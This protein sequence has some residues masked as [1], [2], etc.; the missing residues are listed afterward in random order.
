M[1]S[2]FSSQQREAQDVQLSQAPRNLRGRPFAAGQPKLRLGPAN[3][4]YEQEA[5][6][7]AAQVVRG[8]SAPDVEAQERAPQ[9][10]RFATAP[11]AGI[12]VPP[13]VEAGIAAARG[14]GHRLPAGVR[15]QME[16][17]MGADFGGVRLHSDNRADALNQ[18][19]HA[20][21]FTTGRDIFFRQGEYQPGSEVGRGL[22]AHE[23]AHVVQQRV[24]Y[25]VVQRAK[26]ID[27]DENEEIK[28]PVNTSIPNLMDDDS[29]LLSFNQKRQLSHTQWGTKINI[30]AEPQE[31]RKIS[32]PPVNRLRR[33]R[34]DK[35][36]LVGT[37][38]PDD[39]SIDIK[40][41]QKPGDLLS[42]EITVDGSNAYGTYYVHVHLND[43]THRNA[44]HVK[45]V[46]NDSPDMVTLPHNSELTSFII[47]KF[48]GFHRKN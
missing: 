34:P 44:A 36:A 41:L 6:R 45:D 10:Q 19:V 25:E 5:D 35:S 48:N 21:A 29:S 39:W 32:G 40:Q 12:A 11:T 22:L 7:V 16:R 43:L 8:T 20:R 18:A 30:R 28:L 3:D 42:Y 37:S 17:A 13:Q 27:H 23:L 9:I 38:L 14:G 33:S 47:R 46:D 24:R 15:S 31:N 2:S 4:R 26:L 1:R